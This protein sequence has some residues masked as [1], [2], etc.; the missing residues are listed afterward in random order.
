SRCFRTGGDEFA[1]VAIGKPDHGKEL[2]T[3]L[4]DNI[5]MYNRKSRLKISLSIGMASSEEVVSGGLR[6]LM[7][8][9]DQRMYQEKRKYYMD[10]KH[11]RRN[12]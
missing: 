10:P 1:I 11:D 4:K 7:A 9:A 6:E 3:K 5:A 8:L 12:R 2:L